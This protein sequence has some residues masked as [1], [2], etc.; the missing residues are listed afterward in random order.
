MKVRTSCSSS[1]SSL[2]W[3]IEFNGGL[4]SVQRVRDDLMG[5]DGVFVVERFYHHPFNSVKIA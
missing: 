2:E 5:F 3:G 1:S 4:K